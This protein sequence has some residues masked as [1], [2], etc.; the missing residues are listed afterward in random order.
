ESLP[1]FLRWVRDLSGREKGLKA[2]EAMIEPLAREVREVLAGCL[3][4]RS[5]KARK[6]ESV[7]VEGDAAA[8]R[9]R[10]RVRQ[11]FLGPAPEPVAH[12]VRA[13]DVEL[14]VVEPHPPLVLARLAHAATEQ[15]LVGERI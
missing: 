10:D 11:G 3:P 7:R 2:R 15:H 6:V 1:V 13:L 14:V 9:D 5:R 4:V 8:L 12:L